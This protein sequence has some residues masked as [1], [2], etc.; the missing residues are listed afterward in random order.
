MPCQPEV[1]K[2]V[3][4]FEKALW[5]AVKSVLGDDVRRMGCS[6]HWSQA[7]WRKVVIPITTYFWWYKNGIFT[8]VYP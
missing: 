1:M 4:D 6:F 3:L 8:V 5:A 7:V 2:V